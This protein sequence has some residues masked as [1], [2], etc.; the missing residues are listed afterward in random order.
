M[1]KINIT[2]SVIIPAYNAAQFIDE[3]LESALKQ[4]FQEF[5]II[6]I[7]DG[8]K[9]RTKEIVQ[10]YI[11]KFP[12]KIKYFYQQN[13]GVGKARNNGIREAQGEYIAFLDADDQWFPEKLELQMTYFEKNPNID[14]LYSNAVIVDENSNDLNRLYVK[15]HEF[16]ISFERMLRSLIHR[17]FIPVS[18]I[19]TKRAVLKELG[20]YDETLKFSENYHLILRIAEKFK[21]GSQCE[22]TMKY[23]VSPNNQSSHKELVN[24]TDI[25]ILKQFVKRNKNM[26]ADIQQMVQKR[27]AR[28]HYQLGYELF[29]QNHFIEARKELLK[30]SSAWPF[31]HWKKYFYLVFTYIG[32]N[33]LQYLR[34]IK[35]QKRI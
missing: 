24:R 33:K 22:I 32:E 26:S 16:K 11:Q 18:S 25:D 27:L 1:K 10:C 23:R 20:G 29:A 15:K 17:D 31:I 28:A 34:N 12:D 4:T 5:E 3:A 6:V 8:S 35:N 13:G 2:V 21:M 9:D 19:M 14:F 7:D 30:S